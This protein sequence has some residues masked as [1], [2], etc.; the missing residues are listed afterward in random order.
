MY[1]F[2]KHMKHKTFTDFYFRSHV[3]ENFSGPSGCCAQ[4]E[5][6]HRGMNVQATIMK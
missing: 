6:T 5:G 1:W 3:Y 4:Q 2:F